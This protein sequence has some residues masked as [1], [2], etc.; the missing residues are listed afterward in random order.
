[1]HRIVPIIRS[2]ELPK[3]CAVLP[4][5]LSHALFEINCFVFEIDETIILARIEFVILHVPILK[6]RKRI[7]CHHWISNIDDPI[8]YLSSPSILDSKCKDVTNEKEEITIFYVWVCIIENV[9]YCLLLGE[10]AVSYDSFDILKNHGE[11]SW[12]VV[13]TLFGA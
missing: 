1:M 3:L 7:R 9:V 6:T 5:I 4:S 12:T 11:V 10:V 13:S 2:L 8:A